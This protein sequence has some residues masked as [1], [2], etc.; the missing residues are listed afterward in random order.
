MSAARPTASLGPTL[1]SHR[2]T[3][4]HWLTCSATAHLRQPSG[5][6]LTFVLIISPPPP[7]SRVSSVSPTTTAR[8]PYIALCCCIVLLLL[9]PPLLLLLLGSSLLPLPRHT[10]AHAAHLSAGAPQTSSPPPPGPP[11][12]ACP[13]ARPRHSLE[14]TRRLLASACRHSL[15]ALPRP[16]P[17]LSIPITHQASPPACPASLSV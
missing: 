15:A 6:T 3:A 7:S 13:P 17:S 5:P 11:H 2:S 12:H 14:S 4:L 16:I 1:H 10:D 8:L 9:P